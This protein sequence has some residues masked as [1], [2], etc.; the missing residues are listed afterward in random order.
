MELGRGQECYGWD[1]AWVLQGGRIVWGC[2][3][4]L[5][6]TIPHHKLGAWG[7]RTE[8]FLLKHAPRA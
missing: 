1:A 2:L 6:Q 5:T 3:E 8:V 7:P 4:G